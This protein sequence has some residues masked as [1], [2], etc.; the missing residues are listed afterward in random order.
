MIS[1]GDRSANS[2]GPVIRAALPI[3]ALLTGEADVGELH[4]A[5]G[6]EH[7]VDLSEQLEFKRRQVDDA[8]G[9]HVIETLIPKRHL[10]GGDVVHLDSLISK[11]FQDTP[12]LDEHFLGQI[13]AAHP[14]LAPH[15]QP[16]NEQV[17]AGTAAQIEDRAAFRYWG[18]GEWIA[19]TTERIER[20]I[21]QRVEQSLV[22]SQRNST[23]SAGVIA[24]QPLC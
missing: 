24:E 21:G 11:T 23:L 5:A 6:F 3:I 16:G 14:P 18:D 7:P 12:R 20:I 1:H 19:D 8:I 15:N 4:N 2:L 13:N 17:E 22:V 10:L 9:N